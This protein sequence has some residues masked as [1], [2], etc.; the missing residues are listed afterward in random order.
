MK[1]AEHLSWILDHPVYQGDE[2]YQRNIDFCHSLGLKCDCVGWSEL[3]L[4]RPDADEILDKIEAF[5]REE[6][7]FAR[8]GYG[9]WFEL[10]DGD[11]PEW[12]ELVCLPY[13]K[14]ETGP[15]KTTD[16]NGN[17]IRIDNIEAYKNRG[18]VI[19][20][21]RYFFVSERFKEV[22]EANH[23]PV[24]FLW[25]KDNGKFDSPQYFH[26]FPQKHISRFAWTKGLRYSGEWRNP[27]LLPLDP[28]R[29]ARLEAL[30]GKGLRIAEIFYDLSFR[31]PDQYP[32]Q[33]MPETGFLY[34]D[35]GYDPQMSRNTLL[36]HRET[37]EIL[38][39]EKLIT[40][41]N[42]IPALLYDE[43]PA[44]YVE[45]ENS[46]RPRP[47]PAYFEEMQ[48]AYEHLKKNPK[49]KRKATQIQT[50][51]ILRASKRERKED[52]NKAL[53]KVVAQTLEETAYA[54]LAPYY[55][56]S[57]GFYL[58][59]EYEVLPYEKT[60]AATAEF[61]ADMQKE[62]LL[63]EIPTGIV[64]A[65]CPDGD[66]VLLRPSGVVERY[67]HEEPTVSED[68]PTLAQFFM[69]CCENES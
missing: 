47:T 55:L 42:L 32:K 65:R 13:D 22:C 45:K 11:T 7:W 16:E 60:A 52:F 9:K 10:E 66:R 58:S 21:Y 59:D 63:E 25:A 51:K 28:V 69:D 54:P 48:K 36:V 14:S 56:L 18:S 15:S 39:K 19:N 1:I 3:D 30:G 53:K 20:A 50:L 64:I 44:G 62:E 61:D 46:P 8:G 23:I 43:L 34:I 29:K 35:D 17:E 27:Q 57:N 5:C 24:D 26:I 6:G 49:P 68:W 37:A 4:T 41:K 2:N 40:E 38:L 33:E 12:F 67:S 31:Y